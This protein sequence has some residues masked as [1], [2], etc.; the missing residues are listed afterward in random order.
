MCVCV[1]VCVCVCLC[2]C[3]HTYIYEEMRLYLDGYPVWWILISFVM[4]CFDLLMIFWFDDLFL[5]LDDPPIC[6]LFLIS[7]GCDRDIYT[8]FVV[9]FYTYMLI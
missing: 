1:C 4:Y 3:V 7:I 6:Y 9:Y 2:V 8:G 5:N